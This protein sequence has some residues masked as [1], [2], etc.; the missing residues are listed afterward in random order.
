MLTGRNMA[1]TK[2]RRSDKE[3]EKNQTCVHRKIPHSIID[4]ATALWTG[5]KNWNM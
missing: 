4:V 1:K 5:L 3:K 2:T